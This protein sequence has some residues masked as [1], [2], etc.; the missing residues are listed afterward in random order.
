MFLKTSEKSLISF[1]D[2]FFNMVGV[3][4]QFWEGNWEFRE[5]YEHSL[6][7]DNPNIIYKDD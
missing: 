3:Q 2:V 4:M 7:L 6:F 1:S 5:S